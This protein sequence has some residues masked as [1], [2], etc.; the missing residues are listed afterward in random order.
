MRL[1]VKQRGHHRLG[2]AATN[3]LQS[4]YTVRGCFSEQIYLTEIFK[5]KISCGKLYL[6]VSSGH[7]KLD[8]GVMAHCLDVVRIKGMT[9][10]DIVFLEEEKQFNY[11]I[12]IIGD[13]LALVMT[14]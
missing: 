1:E 12:L 4:H 11:D 5:Y 7:L 3:C 14:D 2:M 9:A 10:V 13:I 8:S 6:N